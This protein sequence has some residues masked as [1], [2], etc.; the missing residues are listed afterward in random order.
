MNTVS[1]RR[2]PGPGQPDQLR[3]SQGR[4]RGDDDHRQPRARPLRRAG[5]RIAPG[6]FTRMV[7]PAMPDI[8]IKQ[9][10][11]VRDGEFDADEPGQLGPGGRVPGV[12]RGDAVT[13]QV[14]RMVGNSLCRYK[15][16]EMGERVLRHRQGGQPHA[17]GPRRHRRILG[18]YHLQ[19]DEPGIDASGAPSSPW[20]S[21]P[22][23][24]TL[25]YEERDGVAC[26]SRSTGPRRSTR[27]TPRCSRSCRRVWR[28]LRRNDDVRVRR[29]HRRGREGVLHRH[30]PHGA[31]GRRRPPTPIDDE[32]A[33]GS[34]STPFMFNDPGDLHRAEELR[35]LEAGHRRGERHGVRRRVLHARRGRVHHRAEHA[36]F[37]DPHVT[38]GMTAAFEPIHM[39][40]IDAVRRDHAALAARATTSACRPQRAHEIG[41]VSEVAPAAELLDRAG[42]RPTRDRLA[43]RAGDRG[44]RAGDLGRAASSARRQALELGV[45]VSPSA[46]TRASSQETSIARRPRRSCRASGK[47]RS[48]LEAPLASER[49]AQGGDRRGRAVRLRAGRHQVA[50]RA[51]LP[52]RRAR[53]SPTPGSPRTT[54]TAS[55]RT[56]WACSPRS[57]SPSTSACGPPGSTAPA[58]AARPGSFMAEHAVEAI[59]AGHAEVVV[60]AYGSTTR[61]DLKSKRRTRQPRVRH[62]RPVQFDAPYGHTLIAKYA[63]A[64]PPAHVRVRHHRS[65]S[66]PRSRFAPGTTP[67]LNPDAYYRDPITI[68]DV[69]SLAR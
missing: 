31:D 38:Y 62:A 4:H 8:E 60:L 57:R 64:D 68:D 58:S 52:G 35:P 6:G 24:E 63:M 36:T 66:S 23:F 69:Q 43:A 7:G 50:V 2:P 53:A 27:S 47:T 19:D 46:P 20:P 33:I 39:S 3:R 51:P 17:V 25:L 26:A 41:M 40:G 44:H 29:A 21:T 1:S 13:G 32:D 54:S 11:R 10:R 16:W 59:R 55:A 22:D 45:R 67:A 34:G 12:R 18:R 42:G 30:R 49:G 48:S 5:Q 14:L 65:S 37:F 28:A 56:A 61:A 9:A 15:P